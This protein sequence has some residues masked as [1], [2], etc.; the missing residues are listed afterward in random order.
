MAEAIGVVASVI[1]VVTLAYNSTKKLCEVIHDYKDASTSLN[2]IYAELD[3]TQQILQSLE[4]SLKSTKDG[5]L[6]DPVTAC[7]RNLKDPMQTCRKTLDKFAKNISDKTSNSSADRVSRRDK[8]RLL[9]EEK[10]IAAFKSRVVSHKLT[11][12]IALQLVTMYV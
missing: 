9:F 4:N 12:T 11:I 1:A 2:D 7:L 10:G 3:A 8:V 5:T 6:S